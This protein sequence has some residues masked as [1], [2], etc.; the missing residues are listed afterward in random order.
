MKCSTLY[1][2]NQRFVKVVYSGKQP[3]CSDVIN[4]FAL[5][6]FEWSADFSG[7]YSSSVCLKFDGVYSCEILWLDK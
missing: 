7:C 6:S 1:S 4:G 3:A 2:I 5:Y